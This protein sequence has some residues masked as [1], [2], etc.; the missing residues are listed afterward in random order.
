MSINNIVTI[1]IDIAAPAVD[2]ANFDNLLI[3][4]PPPAAPPP[5]PLPV[6]GVY[7]DLSEVTGAGYVAIGPDADP[8]G[9]AARIAFSQSPKPAQIFV[10]TVP[11]MVPTITGGNAVVITDANY[12]S[13]AQ[14]AG[15]NIPNPNDFPWLQVRYGRKT[16]AEMEIIVEKDGVI[17]YGNHLLPTSEDQNAFEQIVIGKPLDTS[18]ASMDIPEDKYEGVYLITLIAIDGDGRIT[19]IKQSVTFDGI[20]RTTQNGSTS[21]MVPLASDL[22]NALDEALPTTGWYIICAA[23]IDESRFETIA[24]WTEA[25]VKLFAY[26]FLSDKDPVG[27]IFFRSHGWCGLIDDFDLPEDVPQ[28]NSYVHIAAVAKCLS[29]P[30]GSETWAF[31]RL[32]AVFPSKLSGTLIKSL[33]DGHSNYF[34]QIAGRNITMNG[35]VR[36]GEWIDVIRGRDWLQNDMQL[37][38][39]NLLLMNPKIPYTNSGIALVQNE[40]IASLKA[41]QT[42]GIVAEDEFDEEGD[43]VPGFTT[44]VPNSMSVTASQKASR[45]LSDCTFSARLAGAIH[46][47]RVDGVLTY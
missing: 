37:R 32:A 7:N 3:F 46:A 35:Q 4:G 2:S 19:T 10:T 13:H 25:H 39:F 26:T 16:V 8:I 24:E 33:V 43:L 30:S 42:R 14:G 31:K 5:R 15:A 41:A 20:N 22:A 45:A 38:I 21:S 6:V 34:T 12:A 28:A 9:V 47:V 36:G 29:H 17:V 18:K 44:S 40:M 27:A 23:G 1:N 11:E